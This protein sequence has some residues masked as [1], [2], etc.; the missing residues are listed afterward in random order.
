[1]QQLTV[2]QRCRLSVAAPELTLW[3]SDESL[4]FS[5]YLE[6]MAGKAVHLHSYVFPVRYRP[7][8]Q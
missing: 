1:V 5:D 7:E 4:I 8:L 3:T 6:R 2:L